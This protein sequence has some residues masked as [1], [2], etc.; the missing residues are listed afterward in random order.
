MIE[1]QWTVH[2]E[3]VYLLNTLTPYHYIISFLRAGPCLSS[4]APLE[5][6]T[7]PGTEQESVL[8]G[9]GF[10]VVEAGLPDKGL[11]AACPATLALPLI[12]LHP[13]PDSSVK[14]S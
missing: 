5:P 11:R 2:R 14:W 13:K 12:S 8:R 9:G 6:S 10:L 4:R 1:A 3:F 7:L